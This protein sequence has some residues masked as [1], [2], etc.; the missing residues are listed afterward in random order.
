MYLFGDW[1]GGWLTHLFVCSSY[2]TTV[3]E[4]NVYINSVHI[5]M[6]VMH[7]EAE[8]TGENMA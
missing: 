5:D 8:R 6:K 2:L 1:L 3:C 4:V 7:S